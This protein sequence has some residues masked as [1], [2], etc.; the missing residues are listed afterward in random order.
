MSDDDRSTV[1]DETTCR[2]LLGAARLGRV[3]F[4][5]EPSPTILPVNYVLHRDAVIFRTVEGS[6]LAAAQQGTAA[7]FEVDGLYPDHDSG[8]SVLVRG[9][10]A[11]VDDPDAELGE[12]ADQLR[13]V[14]GGD[15]PHLVRLAIDEI[16]GRQIRADR[17]FVEAHTETNTWLDRDASDLLG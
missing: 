14:V 1:L 5:G 6:K 4:N 3:A 8:W 10:L 12:V 11:E 16:T 9:T 13:P 15:R 7:S 17:V 2:Q